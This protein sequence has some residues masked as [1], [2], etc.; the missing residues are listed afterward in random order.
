MA[1]LSKSFTG[2]EIHPIKNKH[3]REALE[4]A[5]DKYDQI[6][7][8]L[9][10]TFSKDD[11]TE[12]DAPAESEEY[13]ASRWQLEN[14]LLEKPHLPRKRQTSS[15]Q[16]R[17]SESGDSPTTSGDLQESPMLPNQHQDLPRPSSSLRHLITCVQASKASHMQARTSRRRGRDSRVQ[18]IQQPARSFQD[19]ASGRIPSRAPTASECQAACRRARSLSLELKQKDKRHD[20]ADRHRMTKEIKRQ[21][22]IAD[23]GWIEQATQQEL[24]VQTTRK[25]GQRA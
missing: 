3:S 2:E 23:G 13:D 24:A 4:D 12:L 18:S 22:A 10:K 21:D 16:P 20:K 11:L 7:A 5:I 25:P 17:S 1:H 14:S 6:R 9:T 19:V 15:L 8:P